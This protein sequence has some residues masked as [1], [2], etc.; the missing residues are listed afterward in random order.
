MRRRE[1]ARVLEGV[2]G[3][4][5]YDVH[6]VV[7]ARIAEPA[8][9]DPDDADPGRHQPFL[10]QPG[11][12]TYSFGILS[13]SAV[14]SIS[15]GTGRVPVHFTAFTASQSLRVRA[16]VGTP[17]SSWRTAGYWAERS[18]SSYSII[19][20]LKPM[21]LSAT[22]QTS[23]SLQV[24]DMVLHFRGE[25]LGAD[26]QAPLDRHCVEA[27]AE[28]PVD[29]AARDDAGDLAVDGAD[30]GELVRD[31]VAVPGEDLVVHAAATM[32]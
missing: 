9:P 2:V 10:F 23:S 11:S 4:V 3:R 29:V 26:A 18:S 14:L 25:E 1:A 30:D 16:K 31:A 17:P 13:L 15:G 20:R 7:V 28:L 12:W 6:E 32:S 27:H 24:L 21:G 8:V 5:G 22:I 19:Q